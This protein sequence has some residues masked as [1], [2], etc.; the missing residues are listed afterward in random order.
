[1]KKF[2][3]VFCLMLVGLFLSTP[4][5]GAQ[6]TAASIR[7]T[8]VDPSGALISNA[9]LTATQTETGLTREVSSD[10]HG[11]YIFVELPIGD[12]KLEA[13]A[14]GFQRY[15][16]LGITLDVNQRVTITIQLAVGTV[17]QKTEVHANAPL[18]E[19]SVTSLG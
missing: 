5:A 15:E 19:T 12:Y 10:S 18:V 4:N 2:A 3:L 16:Q 9:S 1:M 11:E 8:V 17:E 6:G 7:G 14:K 13:Q